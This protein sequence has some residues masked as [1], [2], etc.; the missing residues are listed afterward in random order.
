MFLLSDSK[1]ILFLLL[2]CSAVEGVFVGALKLV[3]L[4]ARFTELS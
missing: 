4:S 2:P 3:I 1:L